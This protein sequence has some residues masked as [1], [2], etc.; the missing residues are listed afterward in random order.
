MAKCATCNK[1]ILLGGVTGDDVR[2]CSASCRAQDFL[3]KFQV[4]LGRA[5]EANP[6]PL[7]EPAPSLKP[8]RSESGDTGDWDACEGSK[9][10]MVVLLGW[11]G[12]AAVAVLI[13]WL[14]NLVR[15]PFHNQTFWFVI[16]IGAYLCGMAAGCGFWL[17]LRWLNVR[18]SGWTFLAAGVGG[19]LSYL[20]IYVLM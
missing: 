19:A 8:V 13:Y 1:T 10:L 9:S 5:S 18:P 15:Y 3:P 4:A 7:S 17:A 14:V 6:N 11:A 2:F 12:C 16:P 20:L